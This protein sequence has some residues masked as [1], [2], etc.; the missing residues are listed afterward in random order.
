M[1]EVLESRARILITT[2][3]EAKKPLSMHHLSETADRILSALSAEDRRAAVMEAQKIANREEGTKPP[4]GYTPSSR[5]NSEPKPEPKKVA[6]RKIEVST[7]A[8]WT[9]ARLRE[10]TRGRL[11]SDPRLTAAELY[12]EAKTLGNIT[13]TY[14]TFATGYNAPIRKELGITHTGRRPGTPSRGPRPSNQQAP[15]AAGENGKAAAPTVLENPPASAPDPACSLFAASLEVEK[16]EHPP[17]VVATPAPTEC[18]V[19]LIFGNDRLSG[20]VSADGDWYIELRGR[21]D[22]KTMG[23]LASAFLR[24]VVGL[25]NGASA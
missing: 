6:A 16:Q 7:E 9:P 3:E 14:T 11:Q 2:T 13:V 5:R 20:T 15:E 18:V 8:D 22:D 1:S 21:V 4:P 17:A 23:L 10:F 24:R 25:T 19:D 12:E